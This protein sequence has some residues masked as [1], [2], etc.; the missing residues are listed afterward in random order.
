MGIRAVR[1]HAKQFVGPAVLEWAKRPKYVPAKIAYTGIWKVADRA[2]T[3]FSDRFTASKGGVIKLFCGFS[4]TYLILM[5]LKV[6]DVGSGS[7]RIAV[8]ICILIQALLMGYNVYQK[9]QNPNDKLPPVTKLNFGNQDFSKMTSWQI[10]DWQSCISDIENFDESKNRNWTLFGATGELI[11]LVCLLGFKSPTLRTFTAVT[12]VGAALGVLA[13]HLCSVSSVKPA[14]QWSQWESQATNDEWLEF[15]NFVEKKLKS[16]K[17]PYTQQL[18]LDPVI[19]EKTGLFYEKKA[20][21]EQQARHSME[22]VDQE[23]EPMVL[24]P[25]PQYFTKVGKAIFPFIDDSSPAL[26]SVRKGLIAY[27]RTIQQNCIAASF[28]IRLNLKRGFKQGWMTEEDYN[29]WGERYQQKYQ[30]QE[31]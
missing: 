23:Q 30:V 2:L 12:V 17:C 24:K 26:P 18:I 1:G 9:R 11:S 19:D 20:A 6:A 29:I 14:T 3:A 21:D 8:K 7:F 4:L 13:G 25:A 10:L 22:G 16:F 5:A 28:Q 31:M 15:Q 27:R